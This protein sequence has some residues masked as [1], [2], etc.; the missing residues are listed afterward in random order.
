MAPDAPE[1]RLDPAAG[2]DVE[3]LDAPPGRE[4]VHT[5]AGRDAGMADAA[6]ALTLR[7]EPFESDAWVGRFEGGYPSPNALTE[8]RSGP[9][10]GTLV[11]VNRGAGFLVGVD[12][13]AA[14]VELGVS[15]ILGL[16]VSEDPPLVLA[17]DFTTLVAYDGAGE[18]WRAEISWDGATLTRVA[19]GSVHG[20]GWN[21]PAARH[22]PFEV[23][24]AT[25][26][27][28]RGPEPRPR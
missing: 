27:I 2:F 1:P 25:G 24:L 28:V 14:A 18:R 3:V 26:Q 7:V 16:L 22:V 10:P 12:D 23:D 5:F 15:P 20:E 11:V 21:A 6:D 8:V 4:R 9:T 13:P 17:V 19:G